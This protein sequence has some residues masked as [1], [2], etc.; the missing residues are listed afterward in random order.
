MRPTT[1]TGRRTAAGRGLSWRSSR[2]RKQPIILI[3]N[4]YY[5]LSKDLKAATEPVQ[6]RALQAR[7]IVPRLRH[8]CAAEGVVCDPAALDEIAAAPAAICGRR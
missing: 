3:A 5:A 6:F 2:R 4:D 1:C 7:S 8:I